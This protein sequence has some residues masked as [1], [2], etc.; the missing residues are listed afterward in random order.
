MKQWLSI[1]QTFRRKGGSDGF[2]PNKKSTVIC[3]FHFKEGEI[4]KSL[5]TGRKTLVSGAVPSVFKFKQQKHGS[6]TKMVRIIII[7]LKV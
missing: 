4:K 7:P 2:D 5:G 3:E 1:F 6:K